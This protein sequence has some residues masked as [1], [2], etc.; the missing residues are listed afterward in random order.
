MKVLITG[1]LGFIGSVLANRLCRDHTV[2]VVSRST[3]G[4]QRLSHP[5]LIEVKVSLVQDI[6]GKDCDDVDLVIHCASTVDNYNIQTDPYLDIRTNCDGTIAV[7]EACRRRR[8]KFLFLSTFFVYGNPPSLPANE[9]T[10]CQPLGLYPATKL[11]AEQFCR[12]YARLY[13]FDL[14]ICRLT[15]VYGPGE[16]Y[17]NSKK[18]ALNYLIRKAQIGEPIELYRN[19]EF[20]RDY[21]YIDDVVQAIETVI[22]HAPP[23]EL[24]LI[25]S[26]L[27][28]RFREVMD[29][30]HSLTGKRSTI[31][32]VKPPTFHE[33][34][35]ISDFSADISK[36]K[37]LGWLPAVDIEEGLRRTLKS[38]E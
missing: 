12:I 25:G 3:R 36:I 37:S 19:G 13:G 7:L 17:D 18:A 22:R 32:S 16:S 8:P 10:L 26:G 9:D 2:R 35:G 20:I 33:A 1:G 5:E 31:R 28:R 38:Y 23:G 14:N 24:Y 4:L 34:V 27:T 15:N 11:C 21:I 30:L 29:V 6:S